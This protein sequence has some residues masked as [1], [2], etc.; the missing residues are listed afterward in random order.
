M[1]TKPANFKTQLLTLLTV[2]RQ[3]FFVVVWAVASIVV[4]IGM[5]LQ[6]GFDYVGQVKSVGSFFSVI[7]PLA[8]EELRK[9]FQLLL[10]ILILSIMPT[11]ILS[12]LW[13]SIIGAFI[14]GG[15]AQSIFA[16][17][18]SSLGTLKWLIVVIYVGYF[19]LMVLLE[20]LLFVMLTE[21]GQY[22]VQNRS[23]VHWWT[24]ALTWL[25]AIKHAYLLHWQLFWSLILGKLALYILSVI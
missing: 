2:Y 15:T 19:I 21:I 18:Q 11:S 7:G 20:L 3:N 13:L 5:S 16:A 12:S 1:S 10:P 23:H 6:Y 22:Y 24:F 8:F 9:D 25:K 14:M 4:F 17:A